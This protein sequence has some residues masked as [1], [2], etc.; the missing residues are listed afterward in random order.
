MRKPLIAF[1]AL[2]LFGLCFAQQS[3]L[4]HV[5]GTPAAG[6][7]NAAIVQNPEVVDI[8]CAPTC[9]FTLTQAIGTGHGLVFQTA[10]GTPYG[11]AHLDSISA[12]GTIV[13]CSGCATGDDQ[14]SGFIDIAYVLSSTAAGSPITLTYSGYSTNQ[15]TM[16]EWSCSGG[17]I[18]LDTD[19]ATPSGSPQTGSPFSGPTETIGGTNDAIFQ[20]GIS[21]QNVTAV[22]S[23]YDANYIDDNGFGVSALMNSVSG[24]AASWTA[25]SNLD[26]FGSA[27]AFKCQ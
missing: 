7:P 1:A 10:L 2:F 20:A 15:V 8:V 4:L 27:I 25:A 9:S 24:S 11:S 21:D 18:S 5:F 13:S 17:T 19:A 3:S 12:G 14:Q 26:G 16:W 6:G 23:P 22:A